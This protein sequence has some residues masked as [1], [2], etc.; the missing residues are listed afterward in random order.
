MDTNVTAAP[1]SGETLATV[2]SLDRLYPMLHD[3]NI[4]FLLEKATS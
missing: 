3:R 1:A 4:I 2:T